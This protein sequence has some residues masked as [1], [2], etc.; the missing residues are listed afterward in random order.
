MNISQLN[1]YFVQQ[2]INNPIY[3]TL[4]NKYKD[5]P[6]IVSEEEWKQTINTIS[7]K[8]RAM[9]GI[10][11][12]CMKHNHQHVYNFDSYDNLLRNIVTDFLQTI[13]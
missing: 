4:Y 10:I 5:N 11:F 8:K 12:L 7:T 6:R 9:E 2:Y 3:T 13:N 1:T